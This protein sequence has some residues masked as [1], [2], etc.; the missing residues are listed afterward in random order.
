M[1]GVIDLEEGAFDLQKTMQCGQTFCWH[2][3]NGDP[4][5]EPS[6]GDDQTKFYTTVNGEAVIV[7]Q[8]ETGDLHYETSGDIERPVES[9]FR[10]HDPIDEIIDHIRKDDLMA[11]AV[12]NHRGLRLVQDEFLPCLI[13]YLCSPQMQIP[14]IKEMFDNIVDKYGDTIEHDGRTYKQ[15]P[16]LYE[17]SDV[18]ERELRRMGLGYR[19]KYVQSAI[20]HLIKGKVKQDELEEMDYHDAHEEIQ[21]INGVG[22]KVADCV[23][24]FSLGK[25]E[26]FPLDTWAWRAIEQHY[27]EHHDEDYRTTAD[28]M[29]SYFQEYPGYAQEYLFHHIRESEGVDAHTRQ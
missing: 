17:L 6:D 19:S 28:N 4:L 12:D 9:L 13:S 14:R 27:P 21:K 8:D 16:S 25:M 5:Y 22:D 24:L 1:Q 20:R 7:W 11:E 23:L 15:F 2:K 10:L 29:R 26:A 18:S 3:V